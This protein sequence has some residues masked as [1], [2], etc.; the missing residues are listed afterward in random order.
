[1]FSV[2]KGLDLGHT[3]LFFKYLL[4]QLHVADTYYKV[5]ITK[6]DRKAIEAG[7]KKKTVLFHQTE[8]KCR[9]TVNILT[10]TCIEQYNDGDN[11]ID[12]SVHFS[13]N[14]CISRRK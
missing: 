10:I 3:T 12:I 6:G 8:N 5:G 4:A 7:L 1:M 2:E 14:I 11:I 9:R 13:Y